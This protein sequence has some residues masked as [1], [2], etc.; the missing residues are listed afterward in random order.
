MIIS[1][2]SYDYFNQKQN[3]IFQNISTYNS[4]D[5]QFKLYLNNIDKKCLDSNWT[6]I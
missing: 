3:L 6:H 4:V 5:N 2:C 1:V